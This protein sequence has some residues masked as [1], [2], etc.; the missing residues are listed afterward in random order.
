LRQ[1]QIGRDSSQ[2]LGI[3]PVHAAELPQGL[4]HRGIDLAAR[5]PV[6]RENAAG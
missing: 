5:E 2:P 3:D 6:E 4:A 1:Q